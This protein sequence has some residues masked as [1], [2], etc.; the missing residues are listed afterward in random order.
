M[1]AD[2]SLTFPLQPDGRWHE[3]QV[4]RKP[5][6]KWR[7]TLRILRLDLGA[8]EDTLEADW[9]RLYGGTP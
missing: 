3:Y 6:G 5:Q 4:S 1:S 2:K 7:G 8:P 9:V